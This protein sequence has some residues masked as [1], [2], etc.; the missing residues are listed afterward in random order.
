MERPKYSFGDPGRFPFFRPL[1]L[2]QKPTKK[3]AKST[4]F[5]VPFQIQT[6]NNP[7]AGTG[8][9]F[10]GGVS[11]DIQSALLGSIRALTGRSTN[12]KN[13]P[14]F[15]KKNKKI[16]S[17]SFLQAQSRLIGRQRGL[18]VQGESSITKVIHVIKWSKMHCRCMNDS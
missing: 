15:I 12:F 9:Y 4:I 16:M 11:N 14:K 7:L 13:R 3:S 10:T 8:Q 18:G 5:L 2:A 17:N 6:K 1:V